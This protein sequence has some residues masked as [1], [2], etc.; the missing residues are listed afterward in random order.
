MIT[1]LKIVLTL[2]I[3]IRGFFVTNNIVLSTIALDDLPSWQKR[4]FTKYN[5]IYSL[6]GI[7]YLMEKKQKKDTI[8]GILLILLILIMVAI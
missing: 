8:E 4:L 1:V 7:K 3:I 5:K 2:L 6:D